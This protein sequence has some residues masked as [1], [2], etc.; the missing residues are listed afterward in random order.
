[1]TINRVFAAGWSAVYDGINPQTL[2]MTG[3]QNVASHFLDPLVEVGICF[4]TLQGSK[5]L[6]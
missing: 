3:T 5:D 2:E 1:M 4:E 6:A